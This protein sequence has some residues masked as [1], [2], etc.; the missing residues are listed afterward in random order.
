MLDVSE[1]NFVFQKTKIKNFSVSDIK[2]ITKTNNFYRISSYFRKNLEVLEVVFK[3]DELI[4]TYK[5]LEWRLDLKIASRACREQFEPNILFRLNFN[6][7]PPEEKP[8]PSPI[9]REEAVETLNISKYGES[10]GK[11]FTA[12]HSNLLHLCGVLEDALAQIKTT[13]VRRHL[14]NL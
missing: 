12:D 9:N 3:N 14:K 1:L 13:H 11:V 6:S 7:G 8:R 10:C 4:P 5:S 2:T